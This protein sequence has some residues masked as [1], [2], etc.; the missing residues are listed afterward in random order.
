MKTIE[1]KHGVDFGLDGEM[2]LGAFL[3]KQGYAPLA[4]MLEEA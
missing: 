2:E 3:K 4:D 1:R